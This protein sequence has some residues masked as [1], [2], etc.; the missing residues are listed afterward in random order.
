MPV[1]EA[2]TEEW[3][4]SHFVG[5]SDPQPLVHLR[6]SH[7]QVFS[8]YLHIGSVL[9][10][11]YVQIFHVYLPN[12]EEADLASAS[13]RFSPRVLTPES[14]AM[15][16]GQSNPALEDIAS[17]GSDVLTPV[18]GSSNQRRTSIVATSS[19]SMNDAMKAVRQRRHS[20]AAP[21]SS[22]PELRDSA[23]I[24]DDLHTFLATKHGTASFSH[25]ATSFY[26]RL[27]ALSEWICLYSAAT[28]IVISS[29]HSVRD[30][31]SSLPSSTN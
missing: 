17:V 11:I 31:A 26:M 24:E 7:T 16:R 14:P 6:Y 9:F 8:V 20:R 22:V 5:V 18:S 28:I 4:T 23:D 3:L 25:E 12:K 19:T 29:I 27:G 1:T 13:Q 2:L 21:L 15:P 30:R 10:L